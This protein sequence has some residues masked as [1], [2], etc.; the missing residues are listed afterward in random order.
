[1]CLPNISLYEEHNA[2]FKVLVFFINFCLLFVILYC[3]H[4]I[5]MDNITF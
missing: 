2:F 5:V 3:T 1:M 4:P